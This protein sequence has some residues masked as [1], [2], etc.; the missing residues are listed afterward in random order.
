MSFSRG[1]TDWGAIAASIERNGMVRWKVAPRSWHLRARLPKEQE[2]YT[3]LVSAEPNVILRDP[4][5]KLYESLN[6]AADLGDDQYEPYNQ[7]FQSFTEKP[8]GPPECNE[9]WLLGQDPIS[10]QPLRAV[11]R[12]IVAQ[13]PTIPVRS[14]PEWWTG[15]VRVLAIANAAL[16]NFDVMLRAMRQIVPR[17]ARIRRIAEVTGPMIRIEDGLP[18]WRGVQGWV[19]GKGHYVINSFSVSVVRDP[20]HGDDAD[21]TSFTEARYTLE[22]LRKWE[23][24]ESGS[25][26]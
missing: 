3:E 6:Q 18:A 21:E 16:T 1:Y 9:V 8:A 2:D 23:E 12:D 25:R 14:R 20:S 10:Y 11:W 4:E 5:W 15:D 7:V 22:R 19:Y 26:I 24:V 13:D 17:V